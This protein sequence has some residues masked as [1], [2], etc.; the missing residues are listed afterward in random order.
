MAISF[1]YAVYFVDMH[2]LNGPEGIIIII[3]NQNTMLDQSANQ[4]NGP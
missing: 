1:Q 4:W 2:I 3:D